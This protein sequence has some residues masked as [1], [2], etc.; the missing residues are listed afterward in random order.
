MSAPLPSYSR[1]FTQFTRYTFIAGIDE[2]GRGC[3]AGPVVSAILLV[4][5]HD[6][7]IPGVNDSKKLSAKKR[8][9]L[10]SILMENHEWAIGEASNVEID[11]LG[12]VKAT[13]LSMFRAYWGLGN[14][15]DLILMDGKKS[16]LSISTNTFHYK[17]GDARIY[18]IAGASIIAKVYRDK[19]IS[20]IGLSMPEYGF[21]Q[22]KGYGTKMHYES[23]R[24]HG[25]TKIHR[26]SFLKS[27]T[28]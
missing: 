18:S 27:F 25:I 1:E 17:K 11:Q 8:E 4:K 19:L 22:H 23:L 14:K 16:T 6:I 5:K 26:K 2:V 20:N 21:A 12:I 10:S 28:F 15:P 9:L 13:Q 24:A 7:I 3:I